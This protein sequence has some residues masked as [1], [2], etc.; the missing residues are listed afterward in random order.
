MLAGH[1]Q[2][3]F[4]EEG[5]EFLS[6]HDQNWSQPN[7]TTWITFISSCSLHGDPFL[8]PG[9][10]FLCPNCLS[11]MFQMFL[12]RCQKGM[13]F[14]ELNGY[15]YAQTGQSAIGIE[16]FIE[17]RDSKPDEVTMV[18]VISSYGHL[19]A[20][21]LN[22]GHAEVVSETMKKECRRKLDGAG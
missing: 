7:E 5:S 1:L 10:C 8:A 3:G 18:S 19:G 16:L 9:T 6:W 17:H 15:R 21:E 11:Y 14:M 13:L 20:L 4:S 22:R 12:R 2:N